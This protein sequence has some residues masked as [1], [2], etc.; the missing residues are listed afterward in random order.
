M[1]RVLQ[2]KSALLVA[3]PL[4]GASVLIPK[5]SRD[6]VPSFAAFLGWRGEWLCHF[7]DANMV[8]KHWEPGSFKLLFEEILF[9]KAKKLIPSA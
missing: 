9:C 6:W 1:Q 4:L 7:V 5:G 8:K 2:F 3:V